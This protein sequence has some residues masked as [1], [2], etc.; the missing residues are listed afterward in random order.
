MLWFFDKGITMEER[1][2]K[3]LLG[4]LLQESSYSKEKKKEILID[5]LICIDILGNEFVKEVKYSDKMRQADRMQIL[6]YL[7]Y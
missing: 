4:K 2:D 3:V 6:Y 7:Y 5:N 1:S